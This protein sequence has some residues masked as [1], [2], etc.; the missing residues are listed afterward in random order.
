MMSTTRGFILCGSVV[1]Q[2]LATVVC[3]QQPRLVLQAQQR[4]S[5]S[6]NVRGLPPS[7]P[8]KKSSSSLQSTTSPTTSKAEFSAQDDDDNDDDD[9]ANDN[10]VDK[11]KSTEASTK[12]IS[13]E[14]D[15]NKDNTLEKDLKTAFEAFEIEEKKLS[16]PWSQNQEWA[17]RDNLPKYTVMVPM[18]AKDGTK[19]ASVV[20]LWRTMLKEVPELA[21]Y[22]I[23]FLQERHAADIESSDDGDDKA[24]TRRTAMGGETPA[25]L[26]YLEDY[27]FM[28]A[29]GISGQVYGIPGLADGARIETSAVTNIELTLTKGFICTSDGSAAYELGRPKREAFADVASSLE[30]TAKSGSYELLKTVSDNAKK[31]PS[32]STE[33]ME[34]AD[35]MLVRLGASAGILL[36]GATAMNMLAHHLTVNVFWV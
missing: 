6:S 11:Q 20:A 17:L 4:Q 2:L 15:D 35:G 14:Q 32:V 10:I 7:L 36:A 13:N 25:L 8:Y 1:V 21:G 5:T 28:T 22:P 23:D 19:T 3:F 24:A 12:K 31:L 29:G 30:S 33:G 18:T 34:N 27:E 16:M 9:D 26:P